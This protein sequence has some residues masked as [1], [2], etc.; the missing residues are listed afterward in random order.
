MCTRTL[1]VKPD[2]KRNNSRHTE[3]CT[4]MNGY[5]KKCNCGGLI[6]VEDTESESFGT[7]L[8]FRCDKC[9]FVFDIQEEEY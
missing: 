9:N 1:D 4:C 3:C 2:I 8:V 5:P 6:H 7:L